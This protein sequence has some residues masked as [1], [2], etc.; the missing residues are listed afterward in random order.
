MRL[1]LISLAL[2]S[3]MAMAF[4]GGSIA[5]T[6]PDTDG[7]GVFNL[8]DN[9]KANPNPG[10]PA[11]SPQY[12][13]DKDGFG[14]IC[15]GDFNQTATV[16]TTDFGLFFTCFTTPGNATGPVTGSAGGRDCRNM[17]MNGTNTINTADFGLFFA[18]FNKPMPESGLPCA[19]PSP[20]APNMT[21]RLPCTYDPTPND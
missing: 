21:G 7:D 15:D 12:D 1:G 10:I 13:F 8:V 5:G 6:T 17:D 19:N 16:N 20:L 11:T 18:T 2:A 3:A 4:A 9:C 14:N